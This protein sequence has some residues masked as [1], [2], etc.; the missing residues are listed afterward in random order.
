MPVGF[1]MHTLGCLGIWRINQAER[2]FALVIE[3]VGQEF[4]TILVLDLQVFAMR[5]GYV[6]GRGTLY[7]VAVD[8]DRHCFLLH[9]GHELI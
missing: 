6:G 8:E 1:P 4:D 5:S 7:V 3:P 2:C 9:A